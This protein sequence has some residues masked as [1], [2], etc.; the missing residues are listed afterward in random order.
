[1]SYER[2]T[3]K[4]VV[5]MFNINANDYGTLFGIFVKYAAR[6]HKL[7]DKIENG[8]LIE[9]PYKI[10]DTVF[11]INTVI[12]PAD[13]YKTSFHRELYIEKAKFDLTLYGEIGTRTFFTKEQA[14]A[15]LKEL[16]G[17]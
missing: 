6:L 5:E 11:R 10:G 12:I 4:D 7:E 14:K 15:R 8:T 16:Q 9:L 1:M 13:D 17:E 2:V 3:P